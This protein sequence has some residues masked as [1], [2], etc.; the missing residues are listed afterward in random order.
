MISEE[1]LQEWLGLCKTDRFYDI[2]RE[3]GFTGE[4]FEVKNM[5][6]IEQFADEALYI[7]P[8]LITRV[9]ELEKEA[10]WL[11]QNYWPSCPKYYAMIDYCKDGMSKENCIKCW[12]EAARKAV[13]ND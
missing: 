12:R 11:A 6:R 10:D 9:R 7:M 5:K 13:Q 8:Q 2:E 4:S 1:Q 3:W